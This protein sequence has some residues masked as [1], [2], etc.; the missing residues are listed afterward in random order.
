MFVKVKGCYVSLRH[1]AFIA[2]SEVKLIQNKELS[3]WTTISE[4]QP[5]SLLSIF[6]YFTGDR[7]HEIIYDTTEER[8]LAFSRLEEMIKIFIDLDEMP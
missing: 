2:K 4:E 7:Y 1:I 6:V 5:Q 3:L 8:D